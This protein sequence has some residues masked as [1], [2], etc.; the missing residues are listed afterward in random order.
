[1]NCPMCKNNVRFLFGQKVID[2][3]TSHISFDGEPQICEDCTFK[4]YGE[5]LS[6]RLRN[7]E[8]ERKEKLKWKQKKIRSLN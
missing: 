8:N 5:H 2:Q 6:D 7:L 4:K 1:M 3:K